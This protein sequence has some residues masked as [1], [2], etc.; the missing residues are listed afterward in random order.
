MSKVLLLRFPSRRAFTLVELLVVI[1][2]I[3][4]L[5]AL[6]LPAVQ[7]AREAARRMQCGNNMKQLGLALHNYHDTFGTFPCNI[8]TSPDGQPNAFSFLSLML[9]HLEQSSLHSQL[10]F[11]VPFN[12]SASSSNR[13]L[14]Q[15]PIQAFI[16]PSDP[17]PAVRS[18]I[19]RSWE[20]P[21]PS[22]ASAINTG[23]PAGVT[24][25]KGF[26]GVGFASN[27][28]NGLFERQ[29]ANAVRFRDIVDGTS[30]VFGLI[31]QSPSYAPWCA[32]AGTNGVWVGSTDQGRI[33]EVRFHF[34]TIDNTEVGI[35]YR[36][37]P[38]SLHPGGVFATFAD[39][40]VHFLP[41]TIDSVVYRG[42]GCHNDALPVGGFGAMNN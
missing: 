18:D 8:W 10:D 40:S 14:V 29:P 33:N 11:R 13:T 24:C 30:N 31:E 1:A 15:T 28:A 22:T 7:Q 3:G 21:R 26:M 36:Y 27:P 12:D 9:P 32:W 37:A 19:A 6:L 42:L 16:C 25:Y 38:S 17:T 5:V 23:G 39:G 2:I 35:G 34:P 41:E 20:W 4:V